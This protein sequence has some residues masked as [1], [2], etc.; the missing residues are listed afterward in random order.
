VPGLRR[1]NPPLNDYDNYYKKSIFPTEF[2]AC[3]IVKLHAFRIKLLFTQNS[4]PVG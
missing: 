3:D 4:Y 2:R 1:N